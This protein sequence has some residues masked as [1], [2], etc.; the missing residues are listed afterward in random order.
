MENVF[1]SKKILASLID[2]SRLH[3]DDIETGIEDGTYISSENEDIDIKSKNLGLAETLYKD[4]TVGKTFVEPPCLDEKQSPRRCLVVVSGGVAD[5]VYDDG[6]DVEIFDW[7]NYRDD[8]RGTGGVSSHFADL[9]A[10]LDI[11][12]QS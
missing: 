1:I 12:V 2:M 10:P 4:A 8:P 5:S 9:A 7:D 6:V 11:P 3:V